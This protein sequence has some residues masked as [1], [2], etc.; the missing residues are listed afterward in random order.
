[1]KL[2]AF[3]QDSCTPCNMLNDTL[4]DLGR[5]INDV[6]QVCNLTS[7]TDDDRMLAGLHA[8]QKTPTL[9]L[10]DDNGQ[11]VDRYQGVGRKGVTR[12]LQ[13]RGLM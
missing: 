11:E 5:S 9:L 1:M 12:M 3:K 7:G 6:D 13:Q 10:V 2:I 4:N 8:I